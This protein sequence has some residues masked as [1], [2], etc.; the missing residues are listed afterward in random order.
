[1]KYS[2]Y[3]NKNSK[4]C[5]QVSVSELLD[6]IGTDEMK[7]RCAK[8]S[9]AVLAGDDKEANILKN[10][11]PAIVVSELYKPGAPRKEGHWR[12]FGTLHD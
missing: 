7:E 5:R 6:L 3:H 9:A 10:E 11:L 4:Q 1:M 2:Y 8:I 12:P